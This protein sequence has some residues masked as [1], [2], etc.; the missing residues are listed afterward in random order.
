M[1][2]T[3]LN[4]LG[5]DSCLQYRYKCS[6][7]GRDKLQEHKKAKHQIHLMSTTKATNLMGT[8]N[9]IEIKLIISHILYYGHLF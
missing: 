6:K 7:G 5:P 1:T 3:T 8:P 4:G 9:C 2:F